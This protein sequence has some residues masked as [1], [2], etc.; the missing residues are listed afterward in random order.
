MSRNAAPHIAPITSRPT[1][2]RSHTA[3]A[4]SE[5]T[6]PSAE[7]PLTLPPMGVEGS[8]GGFRG[9]GFSTP[10]PT[11]QALAFTPAP[12]A[13]YREVC[14]LHASLSEYIEREAPE[15]RA[16]GEHDALAELEK[17]AGQMLD[18]ISELHASGAHLGSAGRGDV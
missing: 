10:T 3:Q 9:A 7:K 14:E 8:P 1:P 13:L 5:K 11:P 16:R 6:A 12:R 2:T 17:I 18:R 15:M 4:P